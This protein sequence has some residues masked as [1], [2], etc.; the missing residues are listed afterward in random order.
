MFIASA[1]AR[2]RGL[3][4][5]ELLVAL[6][7]FMA[8]MVALV[9]VER[10]SSKAA[11]RSLT[12]SDSYRAAMLALTQCELEL[13]GARFCSDEA[14]DIPDRV[15]VFAE[16]PYRVHEYRDEGHLRLSFLGNP[17]WTP[18]YR[19]KISNQRLTTDRLPRPLTPV[20]EKGWIEFTFPEVEETH[21]LQV[22]VHA[23]LKPGESY[24]AKQL[25]YLNSMN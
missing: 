12:R 24:D 16:L 22:E 8:A 9:M 2:R 3:S 21:L 17:T 25:I 15:G 23:E 19:L 18:I 11:A 6:A 13:R 7:V 14:D 1:R 10:N 4:L 5:A 20:G